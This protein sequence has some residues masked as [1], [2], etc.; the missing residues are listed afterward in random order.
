MNSFKSQIILTGEGKLTHSI[1]VCL[2]RANVP[3][4]LITEN[5]GDAHQN[6]DKHFSDLEDLGYDADGRQLMSFS[7]HLERDPECS[8][9]ILI[10]SENLAEK[11]RGIQRLEGL[12][13]PSCI[14]AINTESIS[15]DDLQ[16]G[17]RVPGRVIG[18]NWTEPAHTTLFLEI[19]S[20]KTCDAAHVRHLMDTATNQWDKDPYHVTGGFGIRSRLMAAMSREAFYLVENGYASCEDIDR[21]CRNDAGYYLP[22]A[23]HYRYMDLMGTYIYGVV[24][25]D[26]NPSLSKT[27]EVP[28][29]LKKL[30]REGGKGMENQKGF[31]EYDE[32]S[33]DQ[34]NEKFGNFSYLISELIRK[35][36]FMYSEEIGSTT[37]E[38]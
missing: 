31:Y 36:Q 4:L 11:Q 16:S 24:M 22:F 6:I 33:V 2:A 23:G 7:D 15:L 25:K 35:Y 19:I 12:L 9:A 34:W 10:T 32:E 5:E 18:L 30:V 29:L 8:I 21:A 27:K 20:N 26:L 28:E 13:S 14:I 3:V 37:P 38:K 17:T 1:A